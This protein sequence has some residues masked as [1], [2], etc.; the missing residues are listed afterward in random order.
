M[1]CHGDLDGRHVLIQD[2]RPS[3]IIDW[4]DVHWGERGVDLALAPAY[5]EPK[6]WPRFL[7]AYGGCDEPQWHLALW[8]AL[9]KAL[10]DLALRDH[11]R[12]AGAM[13]ARRV[14]RS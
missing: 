2:D 9:H 7:S 4:G 1:L 8:T 11:R 5:F 6:D 13:N 3:A 14:T 10:P 12:E